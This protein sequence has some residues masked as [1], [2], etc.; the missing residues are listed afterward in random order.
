MDGNKREAGAGIMEISLK[1][2]D[3]VVQ[4]LIA[5]G[6]TFVVYLVSILYRYTVPRVTDYWAR[7]S[8]STAQNKIARLARRLAK[9]EADFSD[10]RLFL[11][12]T[13]QN[14]VAVLF[15][16]I[17]F[18]GSILMS[19]MFHLTTSIRCEFYHNCLDVWNQ[20]SFWEAPYDEKVSFIFLFTA[21]IVEFVGI[22][23]S[24]KFNLETSPTKYRD[25]FGTRIANLRKRL[26]RE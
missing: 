6:V 15:F 20:P 9:Y 26:P 16:A 19:A 7:R 17:F 3:V 21:V 14:G 12:R 4:F 1:W 11:A 18:V 10:S 13:I 25:Y 24:H 5:L 2:G 22:Q 8:V 23:V